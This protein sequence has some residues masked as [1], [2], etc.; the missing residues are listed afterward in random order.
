ME[1]VVKEEEKEA[2]EEENQISE[3]IMEA[4]P[5]IIHL[6]LPQKSDHIIILKS[7]AHL[8]TLRA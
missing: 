4:H 3:A 8:V 6:D 7:P 5:E 1:E 2:Q